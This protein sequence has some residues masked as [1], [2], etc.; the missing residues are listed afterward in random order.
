VWRNAL[1][2]EL[3]AHPQETEAALAAG[4]DAARALWAALDGVERERQS[5]M[6]AA[7]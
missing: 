3:A 7:A 4:E 1:A 2:E 6:A 5:R